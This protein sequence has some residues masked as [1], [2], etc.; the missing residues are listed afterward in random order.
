MIRVL[1]A[2]DSELDRAGAT[3][4]LHSLQGVEVVGTADSPTAVLTLVLQLQ[5]DILILD[6]HWN[7][8]RRAGEQIVRQLRSTAAKVRILAH[9][10]Y[11]ELVA[12]AAAA[13]ADLAVTKTYDRRQLHALLRRLADNDRSDAHASD[14]EE[15]LSPREVQILASI[16]NGVTDREIADQLNIATNTVRRH[17]ANIFMKLKASSRTEVIASAYERGLL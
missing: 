9:S 5:P 14:Q 1:I 17:I 11:P 15:S 16:A 2:D 7:G 8:N 13:G 12:C 10:Q 3:V 6:L 4:L